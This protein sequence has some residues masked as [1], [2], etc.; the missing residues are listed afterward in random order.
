MFPLP[1]DLADAF[2]ATSLTSEHGATLHYIP[3]VGS[4]NDVALR[5]AE[6]G[7]PEGTAVLAD[8]QTAGRGRRGRPWFSPPGAGL[9]LSCIVRSAAGAALP[10]VSLA[11]GVATAQSVIAITGLPVG[12]KWPNDV[13]IGRPWRKL[14]GILCEST[15]IGPQPESVVVGIGINLRPAAFPPELA[16]VATSIEI[17]LGRPMERAPLAVEC[18]ARLLGQ[19]G[20][21]RQGRHADVLRDWRQ[22]G[23][24]NVEGHRVRW[25]DRRGEHRAVAR[26]IDTDGALLV[27]SDGRLER[28]IAG[29]VTWEPPI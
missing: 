17:E 13:V 25:T 27:N 28:I 3:E 14:A 22:V 4:T 1:A 9:Y 2:E 16:S 12:L 24:A 8:V 18:L 29:E 7:A 23:H 19:M 15:G 20:R 5:L 10:L 11:A 26:G 21:L 6:A